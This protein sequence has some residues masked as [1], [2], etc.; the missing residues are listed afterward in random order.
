MVMDMGFGQAGTRYV[1]VSFWHKHTKTGT[2]CIALTDANVSRCYI[3]EYTQSVT[4]TWEYSSITIPVDTGAAWSNLPYQ[5]VMRLFFAFACG[6]TYQTAAGT[7]TTGAYFATSNQVNAMDSTANNCKINLVQFEP[8]DVATPFEVLPYHLTLDLC[9]RY[10]RKQTV[11]VGTSTAHTV[12]SLEMRA[13]PTVTGGG[14]GFSYATNTNGYILDCYQT[15]AAAQTLELT[16][17]I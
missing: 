15:T 3:A 10:Y 4:D 2:Y 5:A 14:T 12:L 8:G 6:S 13:T 1:T 16:A 17:E 7:W 11:W 9:R